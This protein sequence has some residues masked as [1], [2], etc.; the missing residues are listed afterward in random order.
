MRA[1]IQV[2][3]DTAGIAASDIAAVYLAGSFGYHLR[4]SSVLE[5]GLF[6][7]EFSG[8]IFS[9]GNTSLAGAAGVLS[10]YVPERLFEKIT[11]TSQQISLADNPLFNSCF[12][13]FM[14]F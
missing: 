1:G 4:E 10:G 9:A 13:D 11:G 14:K 12:L 2:L 8:R 5:I 7:E 3:M 6:P